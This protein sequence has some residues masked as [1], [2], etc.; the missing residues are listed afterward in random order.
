[1]KLFYADHFVLPL[2]AGHRFPMEK[3]ARLRERLA[4]SGH[5]A[6]GDFIVP[7]ATDDATL[8]LAHDA[9]YIH[10][11]ST[12]QLSADEQRR[13]GFPWSEQMVERSR[14]SAGATLA[15]CHSALQDGVAANLAGGTHHAHHDFGTGFCV[16]NDAAVATRALLHDGLARRIA[17]VD[18]DVHQGDGTAAILA[19]DTRCFTL[20]LHGERNFPFRKAVSDLD[21]AL[22]DACG[23]AD[24]LA[25]LAI[26]L[27]QAIH[28]FQPDFVLYLAGADPYR[29]DRLGRLALSVDAL[30]ERDET[31]L[32][33]CRDRGLPVALAMAGGYART[34]DDTVSIHF[35]TVT[36]AARLYRQGWPLRAARLQTAPPQAAP[37]PATPLPAGG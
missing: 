23:D 14:R 6:P 24:Y 36:T 32:G 15:A 3:Y 2:P 27:E 10:R 35:N 33:A 26:G 7:E 16:F 4:A 12:G 18:C 13:I 8:M 1:M 19:G 30:R 22:P 29:D 17:I 34:I 31:V 5:F 37:L 11:V 20:S 9:G 21:I 25:A 28:R